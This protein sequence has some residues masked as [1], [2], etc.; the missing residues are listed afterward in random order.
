MTSVV[1]VSRGEQT[2][3]QA[4]PTI[5]R[6]SWLVNPWYDLFFVINAAWPLLLVLQW[7]EGFQGRAGLQFW[8]VYFVTTPHRWITL[9]FVFLDRQRFMQRPAAFLGWLATIVVVCSAVR[10]STGTLTC[11][12]AVDYVWN[13][14]H[15]AAQH[16]GVY[17]IYC[18][19]TES[20][21]GWPV[22]VERWLLRIFLLYVTLR[23]AI[24]TWSDAAW[25]PVFNV[26]DWLMP[27]APLALLLRDCASLQRVALGR[28]A[29]LISISTLYGGLLWAVHTRRPGLVLSLTTASAMFHA[30]EYLA[31]VS[32]SVRKDEQSDREAMGWLGLLA[33]QWLIVLTSY[34]VVL[35]TAAWFMDQT[36][37]Q[38]W[39][40]LNVIAAFLHYT[41]DGLI[42]RHRPVRV[43]TVPRA[44]QPV[45][46]RP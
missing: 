24:A 20:A 10:L 26:T 19:L 3:A 46:K 33:S 32:W 39:L 45:G 16:H 38:A 28:V 13:A 14:W 6:R 11:L 40:F 34:L 18:R 23:V 22:V 1:M 44:P 8:Q 9:A 27:A 41:Y 12:L 21:A 31:V 5:R 35:G 30:V 25:Q 15:F 36:W 17:R 4:A 42:W 37:A 2:I 7:G 43:G 29:Y